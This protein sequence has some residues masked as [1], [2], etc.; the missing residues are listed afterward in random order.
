V[1]SVGGAVAGRILGLP[2]MP[3]SDLVLTNVAISAGKGMEISNATGIVFDRSKVIAQSGVP[4]I[5]TKSQISG[6][7]QATGK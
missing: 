4:M 1:T 6:I 3:I 5:V 7:D 2:E